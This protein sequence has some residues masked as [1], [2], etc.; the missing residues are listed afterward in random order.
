MGWL[1]SRISGKLQVRGINGVKH[2]V[3]AAM[4]VAASACMFAQ[5]RGAVN[6]VRTFPSESSLPLL[7]P[8]PPIGNTPRP[9]NIVPG[10]QRPRWQPYGYP[11][12][13]PWY[14]GYGGY[15]GG[16]QP[17]QNVVVVQTPPPAPAE[18]YRPEPPPPPAKPEV[19]DYR[20]EEEIRSTASE[21]V[22]ALRDGTEEAAEA[23]WVHGG[24][25]HYATPRAIDRA[26]P[27]RLVDRE[28]T[29]SLNRQRGL[30]LRLPPGD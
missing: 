15:V 16:A 7:S 2:V 13:F 1:H 20:W 17:S 26:V 14:G 12:M 23:V 22:I 3:G 5:Q 8:I 9:Q 29:E 25:L 10:F 24:T 4:F 30:R 28:R 11:S 18:V 27:L 19:R 6:P 21:F